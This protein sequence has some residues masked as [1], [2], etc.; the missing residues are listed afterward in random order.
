MVRPKSRPDSRC[1]RKH[2]EESPGS[3]GRGA[4]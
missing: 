1:V 2:M 4:R 3:I